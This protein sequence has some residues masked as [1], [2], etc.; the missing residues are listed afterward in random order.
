MI[1]EYLADRDA[2][3]A[4][5]EIAV[6]GQVSAKP[7]DRPLLASRAGNRLEP[8]RSPTRCGTCAAASCVEA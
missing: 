7:G 8:S 2:A 6:R 3:E 1:D 4:S 5:S